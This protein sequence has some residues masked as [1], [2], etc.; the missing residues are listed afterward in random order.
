MNSVMHDPNHWHRRA[1]EA[2]SVAIQMTKESK[3]AMLEIAAECTSLREEPEIGPSHLAETMNPVAAPLA[4]T[5]RSLD[6][7]GVHARLA[8]HHLAPDRRRGG[9]GLDPN[10][11]R[12]DR[13]ARGG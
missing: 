1:Y 12:V 13:L 9:A 11:G 2:R 8:L 10:H 6:G 5:A 3:N 7:L 4:R